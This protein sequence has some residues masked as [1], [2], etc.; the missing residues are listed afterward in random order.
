M[1]IIA[2]P[3]Q[4]AFESVVIGDIETG[5]RRKQAQVSLGEAVA[6]EK[7][8]IRQMRIDLVERFGNLP[9]R[10]LVGCLRIGKSCPVN[11]VVDGPVDEFVPAI[12]I[13]GKFGRIEIG[14][15]R[16]DTFPSRR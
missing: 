5:K 10:C 11:T 15:L 12:D 13:A 14:R 16:R 6:G 2:N 7:G 8:H 4:I 3:P 9:R 1:L